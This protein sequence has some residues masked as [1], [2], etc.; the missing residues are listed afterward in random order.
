M[1]IRTNENAAQERCTSAHYCV[2]PEIYYRL[3]DRDD[4]D[5]RALSPPCHSFNAHGCRCLHTI[6]HFVLLQ[7]K[8]N[9]SDG[10]ESDLNR[11]LHKKTKSNIVHSS[12]SVD[13]MIAFSINST[14]IYIWRKYNVSRCLT[15]SSSLL[16]AQLIDF[17][18]EKEQQQRVCA[19]CVCAKD[20]FI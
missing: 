20:N 1:A 3:H 12:L 13:R 15:T 10:R 16:L 7:H 11:F 14:T 19:C 6:A 17:R 9:L 4:R 2:T 18:C 5:D 8:Q